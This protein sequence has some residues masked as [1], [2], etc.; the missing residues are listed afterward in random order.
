MK[1]RR[2]ASAC[3]SI[4]VPT[5]LH[6][7]KLTHVNRKWKD[8]VSKSC[9]M[10]CWTAS[11]MGR[12]MFPGAPWKRD[13]CTNRPAVNQDPVQLRGITWY[14][15]AL[16]HR[17]SALGK[18]QTCWRLL[19]PISRGTIS[20]GHLEEWVQP[21]LTKDDESIWVG[22][23]QDWRRWRR[24][25]PMIHRHFLH[26]HMLNRALNAYTSYIFLYGS[27]MFHT[28]VLYYG[29][30]RVRY[31]VLYLVLYDS[32]FWE[33]AICKQPWGTA[34]QGKLSPASPVALGD[35]CGSPG[36]ALLFSG[37]SQY[38]IIGIILNSHN[39]GGI[40]GSILQTTHTAIIQYNSTILHNRGKL[41]SCIPKVKQFTFAGTKDKR[42][43]PW[44]CA[45][46]RERLC[47]GL[48][49]YMTDSKLTI[50]SIYI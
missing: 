35:R 28:M 29:S 20:D 8:E 4:V 45:V 27:R 6:S 39:D 5:A 34:T 42:A 48:E 26:S 25:S 31:L 7:S 2:V 33:P 24:Q 9:W 46:P 41:L 38:K 47:P 14:S 16:Q 30:Y 17:R 40:M 11:W 49:S 18:H 19:M 10:S 22:K 23:S 43:W 44:D 50:Q 37:Q 21:Q 1:S 36:I 3:G 12:N 32:P 15:Q 13:W